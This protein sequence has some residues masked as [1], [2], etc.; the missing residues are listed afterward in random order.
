ML[1]RR[2]STT[3]ICAAYLAG[4]NFGGVTCPL[5]SENRGTSGGNCDPSGDR[6]SDGMHIDRPLRCVGFDEES[7][8]CDKSVATAGIP[9][10][11]ARWAAGN[12]YFLQKAG[13]SCKTAPHSDM[14]G[15]SPCKVQT[16]FDNIYRR[17]AIVLYAYISGETACCAVSRPTSVRIIYP[18]TMIDQ[19]GE[20][21]ETFLNRMAPRDLCLTL[22]D[23]SGES[24]E[25]KSNG[26]G[27]SLGFVDENGERG[28]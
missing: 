24:P 20:Q 19:S 27:S 15:R 22:S 13:D 2:S 17:K 7:G 14:S 18:A 25:S 6:F 5:D 10:V 16:H 28:K 26:G 4:S 3:S 9:A 11:E 12:I 23:S 21:G 8:T 1:L